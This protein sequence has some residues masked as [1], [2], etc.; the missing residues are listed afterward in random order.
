MFQTPQNIYH[1]QTSLVMLTNNPPDGPDLHIIE[2][3]RLQ[4]LLQLLPQTNV[5]T[6]QM[7]RNSDELISNNPRIKFSRDPQ[8]GGLYKEKLFGFKAF[9]VTQDFLSQ[10]QKLG[11]LKISSSYSKKHVIMYRK[12]HIETCLTEK[13]WYIQLILG[14][15]CI[16]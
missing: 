1:L 6:T 4:F 9:I 13:I 7:S 11:S 5:S 8:N 15:T 14:L 16:Q 3:L 12:F 2:I 10:E